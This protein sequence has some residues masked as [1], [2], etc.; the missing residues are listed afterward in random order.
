MSRELDARV[1]TEVMG[2][3]TQLYPDG[4]RVYAPGVRGFNSGPWSPSTDI[5][6][7]WEVVEKVKPLMGNTPWDFVLARDTDI[8][9]NT[10]WCCNFHA[11]Y[12]EDGCR[13]TADT[14]PEAIC[15]AALEASQNE[16]P[17][18]SPTE[19]K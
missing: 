17:A 2:W 10:S 1:A 9:G 5:S 4:C 14:A 19:E 18:P 3:K 16:E 12:L 11:E 15:L 6:A 7:A 8:D 13:V